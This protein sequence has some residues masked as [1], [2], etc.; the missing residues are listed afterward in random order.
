MAEDTPETI[1]T[2]AAAAAAAA[3]A[4][5]LVHAETIKSIADL[6]SETV[7]AIEAL[8]VEAVSGLRD[9]FRRFRDVEFVESCSRNDRS[10][11]QIL[12]EVKRI[13][14]D[15][16]TLKLWKAKVEGIATGMGLTGKVAWA[17]LGVL[18]TIGCVV[19]G[20]ALAHG[21]W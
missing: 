5:A 3:T 20:A 15:V 2:V 13:N 16:S 21:A 8:K 12:G 4:A 11:S 17:V 9:E 14:S 1:A 18:V 19:L 10:H 6:K 7:A